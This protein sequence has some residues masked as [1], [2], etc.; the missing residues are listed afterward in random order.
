MTIEKYSF[1][2]YNNPTKHL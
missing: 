2:E 1:S